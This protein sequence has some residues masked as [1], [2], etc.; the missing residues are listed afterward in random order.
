MAS[1]IPAFNML[2]L[3]PV[4]ILQRVGARK[5]KIK[6]GVGNSRRPNKRQFLLFLYPVLC[7]P[8]EA[9]CFSGLLLPSSFLLSLAANC[10]LTSSDALVVTGDNVAG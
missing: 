9:V 2:G 10:S 3:F 1:L 6:T 7:S 4:A 5:K 8:P